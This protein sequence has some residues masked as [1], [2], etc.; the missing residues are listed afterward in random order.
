M[1][2]EIK[3]RAWDKHAKMMRDDGNHPEGKPHM[4]YNVGIMPSHAKNQW[5]TGI[6]GLEIRVDSTDFIIMQF[7]GLKDKNGVDIYE[8]DIC[9]RYHL[10]GKVLYHEERAMFIL[11]DGFN[12]PLF[13]EGYAL[14]KIGNIY[15]NPELLKQ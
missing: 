15:Q 3:F 11:S 14:E 8:G 1:T 2:R 7:T 5:A 4:K 9:K 6:D 10:T 12:E 13:S